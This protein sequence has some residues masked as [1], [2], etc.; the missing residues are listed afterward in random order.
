MTAPGLRVTACAHGRAS[1]QVRAAAERPAA[2]AATLV[3]QGLHKIAD[4][5]IV[6]HLMHRRRFSDASKKKLWRPC[7]E[8]R[9]LGL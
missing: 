6:S 5:R 3:A 7:R 4:M 2:L 8:A 1:A 9:A